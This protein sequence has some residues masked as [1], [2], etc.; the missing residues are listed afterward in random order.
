MRQPQR[1]PRPRSLRWFATRIGLPLALTSAL[2]IFAVVWVQ[3]YFAGAFGPFFC[4]S[5][6]PPLA[7]SNTSRLPVP[8]PCYIDLRN[9]CPGVIDLLAPYT[10]DGDAANPERVLLSQDGTFYTT[11]SAPIWSQR[12]HEL[13]LPD[14]CA[15]V[16]ALTHDG[17][18]MACVTHTYGCVDCF[19]VCTSCF[20]TSIDAVS[21]LSATLGKQEEIIPEEQDV[22]LGVLSWSP[23][24]QYLAVLRHSKEDGVDTSSCALSFYSRS[25]DEIPMKRQ[26]DVSLSDVDMC[27]VS[28]ILWSPDGSQIA[29][30]VGRTLDQPYSVMAVAT[31]ALDKA[32][33]SSSTIRIVRQTLAPKRLL[34]VPPVGL[35]PYHAPPY[36]SWTPDSRLAVSVADGYK[37]VALDPIS[38]RQDPVLTLPSNASPIQTFSWMPDGKRMV[39]AVGHY[40]TN[41]CGS[42]PDSVYLYSL[43]SLPEANRPVAVPSDLHKLVN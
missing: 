11:Q 21:L 35:D 43:P 38:A 6:L 8:S 30:L 28:Q 15:G 23:D 12:V 22:T 31:S 17:K 5:T 29:L 7:M 16:V 40:G 19:T 32:I 25:A 1:P 9:H 34:V 14:S 13:L 27:D 4:P 39:F 3:L 37:I 33:L 18:W 26:G 36:I 20:G 41:F 42:P 24:A 2:C 10:A